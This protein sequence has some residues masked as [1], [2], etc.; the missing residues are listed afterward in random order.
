M[1]DASVPTPL[2]TSPAPT[3]VTICPKN[4]LLRD[5]Q[6]GILIHLL[7]RGGILDQF[8]QLVAVDDLARSDGQVAAH[9][10]GPGVRDLNLAFLDVT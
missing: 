3:N 2:L 5:L 7:G 4:L 8:D 6:D 10:E 1:G 9:L